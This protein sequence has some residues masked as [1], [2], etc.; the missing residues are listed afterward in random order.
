MRDSPAPALVALSLHAPVEHTVV[1]INNDCFSLPILN[2]GH[3]RNPETR[4]ERRVLAARLG[5][6]LHNYF[7]TYGGDESSVEGVI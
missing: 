6:V 2:T 1:E 3:L 4:N 5:F 7:L